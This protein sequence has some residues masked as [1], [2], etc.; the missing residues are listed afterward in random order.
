MSVHLNLGCGNKRLAGFVNVD[1]QQ[2]DLLLDLETDAWPWEAGSVDGIVCEH[3]VEHL[4]DFI[5]FI[6]KCH[7]I[8]KPGATMII[9]TPHPLCSWFWQDPTHV[10][11]YTPNTFSLYCTGA[12]GT[13][14]CGI[15]PWPTVTV[16]ERNFEVN[17]VDGR[18]IQAVLTK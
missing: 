8:L 1:K 3:V 14:H 13:E 11:G 10:R 6:N 16:L 12:P 4:R 9:T 18:E 17:G 2:G 7:G 15:T 5:S